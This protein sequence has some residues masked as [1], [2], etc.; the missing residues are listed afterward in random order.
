MEVAN[1]TPRRNRRVVLQSERTNN[2]PGGK[3]LDVD[4]GRSPG[5]FRTHDKR[6]VRHIRH[7]WQRDHMSRTAEE[8]LLLQQNDKQMMQ[9]NEESELFQVM[10]SMDAD[11]LDP[12]T[13]M[14]T[15]DMNARLSSHEEA[16]VL[17]FDELQQLGLVPSN[18]RLS[19]QKKR[20]S[21]SRDGQGRKE[22]VQMVVGERANRTDGGVFSRMRQAFKSE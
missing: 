17:T 3:V 11:D 16:A 14:T 6:I 20:L 7:Q 8:E 10:R 15:M 19:A 12:R 22:K 5:D 9:L 21:V 4:A 13:G 2:R 18:A 1:E